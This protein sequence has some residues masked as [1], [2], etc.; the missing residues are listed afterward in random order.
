M[1]SVSQTNSSLKVTSRSVSY[2]HLDVY[3]RQLLYLVLG[4]TL[5]TQDGPPRSTLPLPVLPR[6][7]NYFP[8]TRGTHMQGFRNNS[9]VERSLKNPRSEKSTPRRV[10]KRIYYTSVDADGLMPSAIKAAKPK[11]LI[12]KWKQKDF[13]N[14][15]C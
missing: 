3:K 15:L 12:V 11:Y 2:T 14:R 4:G 10:K 7:S 1:P 9:G 13:F 6:W 5:V 8:G